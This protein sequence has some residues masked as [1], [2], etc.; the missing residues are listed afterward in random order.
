MP[1]PSRIQQH[2]LLKWL[3][4]AL[5][6]PRL[7]HVSR[8]GIALGTAIGIFFGL[9]L[10]FGQIPAAATVAVLVRANL[11]IS[12]VGTLITNPFTFAPIYYLAYRLGL[13]LTGME[14]VM[15]P[16]VFMSSDVSLFNRLVFWLQSLRGIGIPLFAGLTVLA[17]CS[18][19]I[20]YF[21]I[22][23]FWRVVTLRNWRKRV[24]ARK[25]GALART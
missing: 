25:A 19:A 23:W 17:C 21:G 5:H 10:P 16:T 6:H 12:V 4:P 2:G 8:S 3:G 9:L 7:W 24:A 18:S 15:D 1:D 22:H 14:G 13:V 20:S 11:P